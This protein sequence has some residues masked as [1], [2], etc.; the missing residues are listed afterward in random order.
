MPMEGSTGSGA[1][2]RTGTIGAGGGGGGGGGP[3]G[4]SSMC[5]CVGLRSSTRWVAADGPR[6]ITSDVPS[7][8][9]TE[10]VLAVASGTRTLGEIF[11]EGD[12]A[13]GR[14]GGSI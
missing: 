5:S 14:T 12:E 9:L 10:L 6:S 1:A 4:S 2:G 7:T 8:R 3:G 11:M 13:F